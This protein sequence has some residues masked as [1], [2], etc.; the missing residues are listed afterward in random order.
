VIE[1]ALGNKTTNFGISCELLTKFFF[2]CCQ[3]QLFQEKKEKKIL[4]LE[5]EKMIFTTSE[6]NF[7]FPKR[8]IIRR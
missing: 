5:D 8:F 6:I 3:V 2:V 1:V 4:F 7:L